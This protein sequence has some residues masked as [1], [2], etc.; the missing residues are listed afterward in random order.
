MVDNMLGSIE[1]NQISRI[2][3][4]F[5]IDESNFDSFIGRTGHV[6]CLCD[7]NFLKLFVI[8]LDHLII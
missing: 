5:N 3:I 6:R 4:I 2:D 8:G 1:A 7:H